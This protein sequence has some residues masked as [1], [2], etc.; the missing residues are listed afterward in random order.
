MNEF[1]CVDR[2]EGNYVVIESLNGRMID[3]KIK[4]LPEEIKEGDCLK[5]IEGKWIIDNEEKQKRLNRIKKLLNRM[6]EKQ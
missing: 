6:K 4:D 1:Y 2:I 5:K 3:I